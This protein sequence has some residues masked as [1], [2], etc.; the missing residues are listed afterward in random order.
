MNAAK[1]VSDPA[2]ARKDGASSS[3]AAPSDD[4]KA[5]FREALEKKKAGA[6]GARPGTG[7]GRQAQ[8][9][10]HGAETQRMFRRKSG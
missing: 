10:T 5:K 2:G 4:V 3:A 9:S 7:G 1:P 8:G 6:P